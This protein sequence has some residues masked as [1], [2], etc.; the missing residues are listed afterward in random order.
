MSEN[1]TNNHLNND[2]TKLDITKHVYDLGDEGRKGEK[3]TLPNGE[4]IQSEQGSER[5]VV[6]WPTAKSLNEIITDTLPLVQS[7]EYPVHEGMVFTK[8]NS[9]IATKNAAEEYGGS[10]VIFE[11]EELV[12]YLKDAAADDPKKDYAD[13]FHLSTEKTSLR[14]NRYGADRSFEQAELAIVATVQDAEV[15]TELLRKTATS[16]VAMNANALVKELTADL[17]TR[18]EEGSVK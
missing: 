5:Y 1:L 12:E 7:G 11:A 16:E 18:Y 6:A 8:D 15:L 10:D 2:P 13:F 14:W 4:Y 17:L 9:V 3:I